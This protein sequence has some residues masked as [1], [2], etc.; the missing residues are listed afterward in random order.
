MLESRPDLW[1]RRHHDGDL[2]PG[3]RCPTLSHHTP[4]WSDVARDMELGRHGLEVLRPD[5][6][7]F[8]PGLDGPPLVVLP[9]I[10]RKPRKPFGG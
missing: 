7:T 6:D 8:A 4:L 1:R 5:V 2:H 10:L 3:F 9:A